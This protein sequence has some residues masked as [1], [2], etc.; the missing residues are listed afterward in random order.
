MQFSFGATDSGSKLFRPARAA[1]NN[2]LPYLAPAQTGK[3]GGRVY[4]GGRGQFSPTRARHA[5]S[6]VFAT[7][8]PQ[9]WQEVKA[10]ARSK[11]EKFRMTSGPQSK[12]SA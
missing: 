6:G 2:L 8:H 9:V 12:P 3:N 1:W 7:L 11:R 5:Y 10:M 4:P